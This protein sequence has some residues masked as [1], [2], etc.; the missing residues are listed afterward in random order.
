MRN[1]LRIDDI[2]CRVTPDDIDLINVDFE[3][4]EGRA[5]CI[6]ELQKGQ[7]CDGIKVKFDFDFKVWWKE[8]E[9]NHGKYHTYIDTVIVEKLYRRYDSN[10]HG[11]NYIAERF[12]ISKREVC[13]IIDEAVFELNDA[14]K[15]RINWTLA[16][17]YE[18]YPID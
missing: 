10:L 8:A 12:N 4:R 11:I 3:N 6:L 5:G 13:N 15:Y 18:D 17:E 16:N 9:D 2:I 14:F 7:I 1:E